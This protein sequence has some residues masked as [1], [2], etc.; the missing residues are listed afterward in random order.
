MTPRISPSTRALSVS[1]SSHVPTSSHL[2]ATHI[3]TRER[4]RCRSLHQIMPQRLVV[5][6]VVIVVVKVH[7][8]FMVFSVTHAICEGLKLDAW[9]FKLSHTRI[10]NVILFVDISKSFY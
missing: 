4:G 10:V 5:V 2:A 6:V 8:L 7:Q 1:I 9:S 3:T